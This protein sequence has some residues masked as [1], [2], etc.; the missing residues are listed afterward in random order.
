MAEART[1]TVRVSIEAYDVLK[2]AA[3]KYQV[4]LPQALD[5]LM[6]EWRQKLS[7]KEKQLETATDEIARLKAQLEAVE[8]ELKAKEQM[9]KAGHAPKEPSQESARINPLT[10]KQA[11]RVLWGTGVKG[12]I[13]VIST[14]YERG[15][16]LVRL[17]GSTER[18]AAG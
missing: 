9:L 13:A 5:L 17:G 3:V 7:E 10:E 12:Q 8:K 14:I 15:Y 4:P 16:A 1:T 11:L 6:E 2:Q 18:G